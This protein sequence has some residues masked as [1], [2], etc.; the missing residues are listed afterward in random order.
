MRG[1]SK[2]YS[3]AA[4]VVGIAISSV[5]LFAVALI[6]RTSVQSRTE[7]QDVRFGL[8]L[9]WLVQ[10][11]SALD[12]PEFP[13]SVGLASPL[14]NETHIL[15]PEF[16]ISLG[17]LSLLVGAAFLLVTRRITVVST[18]HSATTDGS[19]HNA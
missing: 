10:D 1:K 17:L 9:S 15:W 8:P 6:D 4:S 7:L 3:I 13:R 2:L 5:V 12:P 16:F 11:Q 18:S 14:E 19:S